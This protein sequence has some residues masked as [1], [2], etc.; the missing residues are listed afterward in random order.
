MATIKIS[1]TQ[2]KKVLNEFKSKEKTTEEVKEQL[3][4]ISTITH[5]LWE[6]LEE[7][8]NIILDEW[9]V[10]KIGQSD[11]SLVAVIKGVIHD[12]AED[13]HKG[14]NSVNYDELVIGT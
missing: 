5:K 8:E 9:M 4:R 6:I 12:T 7:D 3:F 14:T 11:Q 10:N 13:K 1:E 2:F